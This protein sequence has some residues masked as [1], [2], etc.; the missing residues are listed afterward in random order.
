MP[1]FATTA[2]PPSPPTQLQQD[3]VHSRLDERLATAGWGS[4]QGVAEEAMEALHTRYR[5]SWD[6]M[7]QQWL[8]GT[9]PGQRTWSRPSRRGTLTEVIQPGRRR[10]GWTLHLILDTSGS[11][12]GILPLVFGT[13][14]DSALA[15]GVDTVRVVHCDTDVRHVL[16][17][18]VEELNTDT[19][20]VHGGGGSDMCPAFQFLSEDAETRAVIVLTDGAVTMPDSDPGFAVLWTIFDNPDFVAPYGDVL[21]VSTN[22]LYRQL[23]AEREAREAAGELNDILGIFGEILDPEQA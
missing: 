19:V 3:A 1:T 7:L 17:V 18:R 6:S 14:Q 12:W 22:D 11:M 20:R 21:A 16:E 23:A 10:A 9:A 13:L 5:A 4:Q 15:A 8:E 2:C